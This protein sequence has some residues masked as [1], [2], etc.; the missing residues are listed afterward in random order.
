MA[1]SRRR[2]ISFFK[3]LAAEP[4]A[5]SAAIR[6]AFLKTLALTLCAAS[7]MLCAFCIRGSS[8]AMVRVDTLSGGILKEVAPPSVS[9]MVAT[10]V[11]FVPLGSLVCHT[12][13][14]MRD[15]TRSKNSQR[16]YGPAIHV[17]YSHNRRVVC[18]QG[19]ADPVGLDHLKLV[20]Q[21]AELG[22]SR[23]PSATLQPEVG[24]EGFAAS[25]RGRAIRATW[26]AG[27]A[28]VNLTPSDKQ[29]SCE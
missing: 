4:N 24:G 11:R 26:R 16:F 29:I 27:D 2:R 15:Q 10:I 18:A 8:S 5:A 21:G 9:L 28:N 20:A 12:H 13:R 19:Y 17:A 25:G 14:G 6:M 1:L 7:K 3:W 22:L 23:N